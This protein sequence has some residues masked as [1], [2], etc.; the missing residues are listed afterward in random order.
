MTHSKALYATNAVRLL[1]AQ[2]LPKVS[3]KNVS[4]VLLENVLIFNF[5]YVE[6]YEMF[7][8]VVNQVILT[9]FEPY[10][11]TD[12]YTTNKVHSEALILP[13][14][15]INKCYQID[16]GLNYYILIFNF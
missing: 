5:G 9:L 7:Q 10:D 14:D 2:N 11:P 8:K 4:I 15:S 6:V 13:K 16:T 12:P 3:I 1:R